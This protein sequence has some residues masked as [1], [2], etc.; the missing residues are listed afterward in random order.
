MPDHLNR[1]A[2]MKEYIEA[3]KIIFKYQ[4]NKDFLILN[5]DDP[6][7]REFSKQAASRRLFFIQRKV[8]QN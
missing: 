3:K 5:G 8:N 1:Y 7:A 2:S 4:T 6:I